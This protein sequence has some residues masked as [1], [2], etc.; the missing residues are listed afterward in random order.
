MGEFFNSN[1]GE[2]S[3]TPYFGAR[4]DARFLWIYVIVMFQIR[5][6]GCFRIVAE[7]LPE[8]L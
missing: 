8:G 7:W 6:Q 4:F 5:V 3:V 2:R 1:D